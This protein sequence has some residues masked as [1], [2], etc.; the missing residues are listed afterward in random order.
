[1][2]DVFQMSETPCPNCSKPNLSDAQFCSG[3][4]YPFSAERTSTDPLV[5]R[6]IDGRFKIRKRLGEGGMGQVYLAEQTSMGRPVALKVL[7]PFVGADERI[8]ERFRNEAALASRLNHPNTVIIYDFGVTEDGLMFIAMELLDGM[9]LRQI[10]DENSKLSWQKTV[11]IV[12]QVCGS[13]QDAH[14]KSIIHR[15]LK[16]EN[17]MIV[18]RNSGEEIV[19]VLD[20]GVAKILADNEWQTRHNLTAPNE[21][22]GTPEYMS[23]EQ[24]R[25][26]DM[27][28][29]TDVYSLGIMMFRMLTG[30]LPFK[31]NT[32]IA[33][34]A[35]HLVDAPP[36]LLD[37]AEPLNI[38][39]LLCN[40]VD[41][42][43]SKSPR[44]RPESMADISQF[45]EN[46]RDEDASRQSVHDR[47]V[48]RNGLESKT[49]PEPVAV[50][51][52]VL[53]HAEPEEEPAT[54]FVP[55]T[56]SQDAAAKSVDAIADASDTKHLTQPTPL[57]A[58]DGTDEADRRSAKQKTLDKLMVRIRKCRDFP[59]ISQNISELNS[60][61][62]LETTSAS[63]LSNVILKDT[64]LTTRLIKLAN[65]PF[66]GNMRG[67]VTMVSRAVVLMGFDAVREA[68]L[69]LLLFDQLNSKDPKHA[70]ELRDNAI[71]SLM[72]AIIAKEQ[73]KKLDGVNKE[74]AFICAMFHNLGKHAVTFYLP[75]ELTKIKSLVEKGM[76]EERAALTVLSVS[77]DELGQELAKVWE[78][79]GTIRNAMKKL[80][81]GQLDKAKSKEEKL[82]Q[83]A[84]FSVELTKLSKISDPNKRKYAFMELARRFGGSFRLDH[85]KIGVLVSSSV[86]K[87]EEYAQSMSLRPSESRFLRQLL[88]GAGRKPSIQVE[89]L[90]IA[91][92]GGAR[93]FGS[94]IPGSDVP[95][96]DRQAIIDQTAIKELARKEKTFEDGISEVEASIRGR[97][98]LN[99]VM[100]L[101]LETMYRGLGLN[102]V[103][104]CLHDVRSKT[105][106]ARFG[107]GENVEDL[108]PDFHFPPRGRSDIFTN[109]MSTGEDAVIV[110]EPD[111]PTALSLPLWYRNLINAPLILLYPIRVKQFPAALFYGDLLDG[112]AKI[113]GN[114]IEQ[115]KNLRDQ[116]LKAMELANNPR[117]RVRRT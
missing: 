84:V 29:S 35:K 99:G 88:R 100:L 21:I 18:S 39:I 52:D 54:R 91:K 30:E 81:A 37:Y 26:D 2:V 42:C 83:L 110:N 48:Q 79:P 114:L 8:K 101:V 43:L 68:A 14:E 85:E 103:I 78:F 58:H 77:F 15:D 76:D 62:G 65:S 34:L 71:A 106:R 104:F 67:R 53:S 47:A 51:G 3:C 113:P 56:M 19:K 111:R 55:L 24:A 27:Q 98:D 64:S 115:M 87:L 96:D 66:Y 92:G 5:G 102:R 41:S 60:K 6:H 12:Q 40:L 112:T 9:S 32:P 89:D 10:L 38:P 33:I 86:E 97:F 23:P 94:A 70:A 22:F 50:T 80:P 45:L 4:G 13:L 11:E 107:F 105:L 61:V 90:P 95:A 57:T 16:P 1:M 108:I 46:I 25:G 109:A 116:A 72:G 59:A 69:G 73:A 63:Q 44:A 74:E 117:G 36:S 93:G 7:N 75:E 49:D 82:R 17:I 20:F 28:H 31:G